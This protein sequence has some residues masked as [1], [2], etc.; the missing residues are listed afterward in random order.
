MGDQVVFRSGGVDRQ[1]IGGAFETV[2]AGTVI[3]DR[4]YARWWCLDLSRNYANNGGC[5]MWFHNG[6]RDLLYARYYHDADEAIEDG[7]GARDGT[8]KGRR[9]HYRIRKRRSTKEYADGK[10]IRGTVRGTAGEPIRDAVV[11]LRHEEESVV[12]TDAHGRWTMR[13]ER[14]PY[15]LMVSAAAP[16]Y[17]TQVLAILLQKWRDL[18]FQLEPSPYSDDSRYEFVSPTPNKDREIWRCGNCH[19]NSYAEWKGSRHAVAASSA[20]TRAVY[21]R[22]FLPALKAGRATGDAGLCAACH[23]PQAALDGKEARLDEVTGVA[24]QGNH[25]DLCHKVHHTE[26]IDAAGV[27]GSLQLGRPSPDDDRVPGP[28][29]RVYGALPDSDYL[30]MG[31]VYNP[32]FATSARSARAA[33]STRPKT[34]MPA[35]IDTYDEWRRLGEVTAAEDG[36][37]PD[38][39]HADGHVPWRARISPEA[40]L[41]Q[42]PAPAEQGADP[43][44]FLLRSRA[45]SRT[46]LRSSESSGAA[47]DKNGTIV[48]GHQGLKPLEVGHKVPTGS[49]D[50]HLLLVA[51]ARGKDGKFYPPSADSRRVPDHAG[52]EGDPFA[53]DRKALALRIARHDFAGLAG[54]EFAQVLADADGK[55]HV[56]FW[57]ATRVVEDTRLPPGGEVTTSYFFDVP[58]GVAVEVTVEL[59]HRLRF[60]RHDVAKRV[61]GPGARPLDRL[62]ARTSTS[63]R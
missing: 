54:R 6:D 30:F 34:C 28:I 9:L 21:E 47:R 26:R 37:L 50:K 53:L 16:G 52:G 14:A 15:V 25:C 49:A 4:I 55:T 56:P 45:R 60:K 63:F 40:H 46:A 17:R 8:H 62:L 36:E 3:G 41:R 18:H 35:L 43:R 59:W 33:T 2:G 61:K 23:A 48:P 42:R 58:P 38:L 12:R 5:E 32:F 19:R 10:T 29:K 27:R 39:P 22:D 20:V 13:L 31:P 1:D 44:P 11:M 51:F 7:Y 24:A 57:R